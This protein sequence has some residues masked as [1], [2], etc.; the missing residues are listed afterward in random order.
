[1]PTGAFNTCCPRD[2]VSRHNGGTRGSPIMPRD[3]SLS[4][5]KYWTVGKNGLRIECIFMLKFFS[6][7]LT[8]RC[9]SEKLCVSDE[10]PKCQQESRQVKMNFNVKTLDFCKHYLAVFLIVCWAKWFGK[11]KYL[12]HKNLLEYPTL[13]KNAFSSLTKIENIHSLTSC[14]G[15]VQYRITLLIF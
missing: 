10:Q 1:M 2:C 15:I 13:L 9:T 7:P 11:F 3:V 4:D 8:S 12:H 14:E 5:S 6:V